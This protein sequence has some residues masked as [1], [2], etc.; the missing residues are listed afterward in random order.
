M[1][2]TFAHPVI[3]LPWWKRKDL[4]VS[5]LIIGCMAPDFEYFVR[6]RAAGEWSHDGWGILFFNLP[7]IAILFIIFEQVVRPVV[8][9]YLPKWFP[10][11]WSNAS[12]MPDSFRGWKFVFLLGIAGVGSHLLWDQFTHQGAWVVNRISLLTKVIRLGAMEIPAYK[13]AQHGSTLAGLLLTLGWVHNN[14]YKS[15]KERKP[16]RPIL[17]F[18]CVGAGLFI[19]LFAVSSIAFIKERGGVAALLRLV[20]PAISCL[21]LSLLIVCLLF[22]R[23][24]SRQQNR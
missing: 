19:L 15:P 6:F 13:L 20:V 18:W 23:N 9:A 22:R 4:P 3:T 16:L 24:V 12:R 7:V 8:N 11:R 1:P 17:P 10:Y 5:A 2:F 14:L 21:L